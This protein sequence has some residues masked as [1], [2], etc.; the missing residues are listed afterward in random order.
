MENDEI[1]DEIEQPNEDPSV[2]NDL[3]DEEKQVL[4]E[5]MG[6]LVIFLSLRFF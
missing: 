5:I 2:D 4:R 3:T 6:N 1:A